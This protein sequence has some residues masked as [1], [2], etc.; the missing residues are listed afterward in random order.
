[1]AKLKKAISEIPDEM[2]VLGFI[3]L[4]IAALTTKF[5]GDVLGKRKANGAALL[6][7]KTAIPIADGLKAK[8]EV[9]P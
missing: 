1:M 8:G 7:A 5:A 6:L 3:G 2:I 4:G 9:K